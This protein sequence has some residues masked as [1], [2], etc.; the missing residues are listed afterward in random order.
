MLPKDGAWRHIYTAYYALRKTIGKPAS[1][2]G[3]RFNIYI[4]IYIPSPVHTWTESVHAKG[5]RTKQKKIGRV[6][7]CLFARL[8]SDVGSVRISRFHLGAL[9]LILTLP[10]L[11]VVSR[12]L[13]YFY[14]SILSIE[15]PSRVCTCRTVLI[16]YTADSGC[17]PPSRRHSCVMLLRP[18]SLFLFYSFFFFF[19][20]YS[21]ILSLTN[22]DGKSNRNKDSR[23]LEKKCNKRIH[24]IRIENRY[25]KYFFLKK[26]KKRVLA[27]GKKSIPKHTKVYLCRSR[28]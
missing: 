13:F 14:F 9:R 15:C 2:G 6:S 8:F 26:E 24:N 3:R 1:L 21:F 28:K 12:S 20:P 10:I 16:I 7:V 23:R 27:K 4:Y 22:G 17:W 11:F 25:R 19:K 18:L 5:K